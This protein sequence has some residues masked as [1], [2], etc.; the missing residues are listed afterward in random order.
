MPHCLQYRTWASTNRQVTAVRAVRTRAYDP[1][2]S[3]SYSLWIKPSGRVFDTLSREVAAQAAE[4]NAPLFEPHVTL[5]GGLEGDKQ[6]VM[7]ASQELAGKLKK[8]RINFLDVSQGESF[9]RCVYILVAKEPAIM[10]AGKLARQHF[11]LE[12]DY[13]PHASLLYADIGPEQRTASQQRAIQRL[14]GE[15]SDYSTLLTDNGFTADAVTLWFTPV[16]D[17]TLAS[18]KQVAVFPLG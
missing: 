6:Q 5:L 10:D 14:Y 1:A 2:M 3:E 17:K 4:Y 12:S 9:H 7:Q 11:G 18:W 13:M 8:F 16:E 15:G